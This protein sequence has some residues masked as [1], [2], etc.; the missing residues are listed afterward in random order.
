MLASLESSLKKAGPYTADITAH[1][2]WQAHC[3]W[4]WMVMVMDGC[5]FSIHNHFFC[6]YWQQLRSSSSLKGP[7]WAEISAK[8][9]G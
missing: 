3:E 7:G 1:G 2:L 8:G 5:G 9:S 6:Q 4:L